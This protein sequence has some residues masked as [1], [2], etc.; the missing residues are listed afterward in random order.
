V[1]AAVER[2]GGRKVP[3]EIGPRRPGDP[4][5][6]V[7]SSDRLRRETGWTPRFAALDEIVRTAWAWRERHPQGYGDR[8]REGAAAC[9]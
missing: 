6:L 4:P 5:V 1:I 7:A 2:V 3:H 8:G 9:G